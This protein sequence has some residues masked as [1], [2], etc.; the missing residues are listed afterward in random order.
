MGADESRGAGDEDVPVI[1]S[2]NCVCR[3]EETNLRGLLR[4][5]YY[6]V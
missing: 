5:H 2:T 1:I 6:L 3:W 4:R